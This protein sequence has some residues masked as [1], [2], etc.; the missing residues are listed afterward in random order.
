MDV[1]EIF[2]NFNGGAKVQR[3]NCLNVSYAKEN[4]SAGFSS[5]KLR[6]FIKPTQYDNIL[7]IQD[8]LEED[9]EEKALADAIDKVKNGEE[10]TKEELALLRKKNPLM[11]I[12]AL[13]TKTLKESFKEQLKNCRSKKE[14]QDLMLSQS[15]STLGKIKDAKNSG[16]EL[17]VIRQ[18]A[19][20]RA[21]QEVYKEFIKSDEYLKL[22]DE[23]KEEDKLEFKVKFIIDLTLET[24]IGGLVEIDEQDEIEDVEAVEELKEQET[25]ENVEA[26]TE[27]AIQNV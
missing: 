1:S 24:L 7:S 2:S 14:V 23:T 19:F 15:I 4:K 27:M 21:M 16:D 17:E 9:K 11:Y 13:Q 8:M 10:L 12:V 26:R 22:P 5:D 20:L 6:T 3:K 25:L 18:T